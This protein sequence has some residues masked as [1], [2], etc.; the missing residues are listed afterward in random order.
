MGGLKGMRQNRDTTTK[1]RLVR[2]AGIALAVLL[3]MLTVTVQASFAGS[4]R[5]EIFEKI[6]KIAS[7]LS[8]GLQ[9]VVQLNIGHEITG[10]EV[11]KLKA[12]TRVTRKELRKSGGSKRYFRIYKIKKN[13]R[14]YK[15]IYGKSYSDNPNIA[16]SDLRYIKVLYYDFDGRIRVGEII[17]NKSIAADTRDVFLELFKIKYQIRKMRLIDRYYTEGGNGT[18]ADHRSMNDDNTSGFNYRMV[19]GTESISM[20]GFGRAIDVNPFENPWCPGGRLYPN[21]ESSA[22][23]ANRGIRRPHMI[24]S[25]SDITSIFRKHGFRWLGD[26]DTRD[27][28]HFEK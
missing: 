24:F 28:Q 5:P 20:H 10:H 3:V 9:S 17:V 21:Q 7:E 18:D 1:N 23:F 27:Y 15:R 16:L 8:S 13:D 25:D 26:T 4:S 6:G 11:Y 2:A 22:E 12:G 19:A 14:I